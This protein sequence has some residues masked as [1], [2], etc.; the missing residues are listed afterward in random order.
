MLCRL[1][2]ASPRSVEP[3][4]A[5]T[6]ALLQSSRLSNC[7][8]HLPGECAKGVQGFVGCKPIEANPNGLRLTPQH[9]MLD[10][11]ICRSRKQAYKGH[12][13]MQAEQCMLQPGASLVWVI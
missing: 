4:T 5:L 8:S 13:A 3:E 10:T 6:D 9:V 7:A 2:K 1:I 12:L 11:V